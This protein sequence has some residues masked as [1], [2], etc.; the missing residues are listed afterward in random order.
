M[1]DVIQVA[2]KRRTRLKTEL[3]KLEQFLQMA[4][5]LK[6][7]DEQEEGLVLELPAS[8]AMTPKPTPVERMRPAAN[9]TG[10]S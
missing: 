4:E 2:M 3:T 6:K 7:M 1:S 9:G 8:A 5:E 10:G